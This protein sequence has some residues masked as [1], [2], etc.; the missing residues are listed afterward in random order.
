MATVVSTNSTQKG[1]TTNMKIHILSVAA[2]DV[3]SIYSISNK[4]TLYKSLKFPRGNRKPHKGIKTA[5][6]PIKTVY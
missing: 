2:V 1:K 4:L 3:I 6:I 5:E